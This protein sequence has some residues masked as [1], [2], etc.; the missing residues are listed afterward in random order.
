VFNNVRVFALHSGDIHHV[1]KEETETKKNREETNQFLLLLHD[2]CHHRAMQKHLF[3]NLHL[4]PDIIEVNSVD[5]DFVEDLADPAIYRCGNDRF[6]FDYFL[7]TW[8]THM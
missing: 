5:R 2:E 6:K 1:G 8:M 4:T 7:I 3:P